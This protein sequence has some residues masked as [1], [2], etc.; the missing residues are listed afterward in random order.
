MLVVAMSERRRPRILIA[1]STFPRYAGDSEPRFILDF[2]RSLAPLCDVTVL[3]PSAPDA[4]ERETLEG[5]DV[6]RYR[7]FPI[8]CL[9]TL[10]YP[11]AIVSRIKQNPLRALLVPFLLAALWWNLKRHGRDYDLVHAHWIIPQGIVTSFAGVPYVITAHG[12]DATSLNTGV[13]KEL[14]AQALRRA[15]SVAAVSTYLADVLAALEPSVDAAVLPMGVDTQTFYPSLRDSAVDAGSLGTAGVSGLTVVFVGRLVDIKGVRYLIDAMRS[16]DAR[17]TIVGDGPQE[18]ALRAQAAN[19]DTVTFLGRQ[20]HQQVATILASADVFVAPSILNNQGGGEGLGLTIVEA[21]ACGLP[22]IATRTG[23]ITDLIADG[24]N[25]YLVEPKD[26][27][28]IADK[29]TALLGDATLRAAFGAEARRAAE[30]FSYAAVADRY[31]RFFQ[32]AIAGE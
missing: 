29:L 21:M 28:A 1:A 14:K 26:S 16:V 12:S 3:A 31:T 19:M 17:L 5:V 7:Y 2:A 4:A 23:G 11:G 30:R 15:R 20:Q 6:I 22:V 32:Q 18:A 27:T 24:V 9:E 13:I 10:C 8:R 25:G